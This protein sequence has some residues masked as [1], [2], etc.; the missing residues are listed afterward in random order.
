MSAFFQASRVQGRSFRRQP[1]AEHELL[2]VIIGKVSLHA[3]LALLQ[4]DVWLC[5]EQALPVGVGDGALGGA[6]V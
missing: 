5:V 2:A 3:C 6:L 1:R 4:A